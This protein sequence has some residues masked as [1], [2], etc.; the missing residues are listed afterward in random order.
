MSYAGPVRVGANRSRLIKVLLWLGVA[1]V[2]ALPALPIV[3]G[4]Q[5]RHQVEPI[6]G[7]ITTSGTIEGST[8]IN[9]LHG[10][11]YDPSIAF[12][13]R[14]GHVHL[15][16]GPS[17]S[18]KPKIGTKVTVSYDPNHPDHA[19]DLSAGTLTWKVVLGI[20]IG[21]SAIEVALIG[22]I[23]ARRLTRKTTAGA[24]AS[25]SPKR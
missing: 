19:A 13:D 2:A 18:S 14:D 9:E 4:L 25:A 12:F 10:N 1:L 15:F 3:G 11:S 17:M 5:A 16:E 22:W 20:G 8:T 23:V 6:T 21:L 7:G 24:T